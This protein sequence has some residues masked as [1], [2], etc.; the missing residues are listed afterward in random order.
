MFLS[1]RTDCRPGSETLCPWSKAGFNRPEDLCIAAFLLPN[2]AE[3]KAAEALLRLQ[4]IADTPFSYLINFSSAQ[5]KADVE[6]F[7]VSLDVMTLLNEEKKFL[8]ATLAFCNA[9]AS[10][11]NCDRVSLGWLE[12]GYIKL[13]SISRMERFDK[14]M[15][16]VKALEL[17][18]EEALDQDD[19]IVWPPPDGATF[20]SRDHEKFAQENSSEISRVS[21]FE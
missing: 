9:I 1:H 3:D 21:L 6:K 15:A 18:M 20:V 19:E 2:A 7:A 13:K 16:A 11:Y 17:T 4:L 14:N 8:G 5:A 10:R 12:G